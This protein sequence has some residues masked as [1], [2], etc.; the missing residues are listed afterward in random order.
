MGWGSGQSKSEWVRG[1]SCMSK[2]FCI[3]LLYVLFVSTILLSVVPERLATGY[4]YPPRRTPAPLE[5][6]DVPTEENLPRP[7]SWCS[8]TYSDIAADLTRERGAVVELLEDNGIAHRA[9][10]LGYS[11]QLLSLKPGGGGGT[12][13]LL[14]GIDTRKGG[15][16]RSDCIMVLRVEPGVGVFTLSIPRDVKVPMN[17]SNT[18]GYQDKIT[19]MYVYGGVDRTRLSVERLLNIRIHNYIIVKNLSDFN[20]LVSLIR[21]VDVDKHLEG[22]LAL[23]WIRN[24]GFA[25]GDLER[26]MRAQVFVKA[27]IEKSW[28]L[29]DGGDGRLTGILAKAALLFVE[30]DLTVARIL[31]LARLL[32][33]SGF[34]PSTQ[35]CTGHLDGRPTRGYSP[36]LDADLAYIEADRKQIEHFSRLFAEDGGG[37]PD[38]RRE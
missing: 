14:L 37:S 20:R 9:A 21:G 33:E 6:W 23:K 30:T 17:P 7:G 4:L 24:R 35:V 25:R 11:N 26:S 22:D 1:K 15:R 10:E 19:H 18:F 3:R 8:S 5:L 2:S 27:A 32:R 16:G 29:T 34:E 36:A 31:E 12:N 28:R 13:I 38:D